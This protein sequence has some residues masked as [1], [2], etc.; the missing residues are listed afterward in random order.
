MVR[1]IL[2]ILFITC[3]IINIGILLLASKTDDD[4]PMNIIY[5]ALVKILCFVLSFILLFIGFPMISIPL[6]SSL[7]IYKLTKLVIAITKREYFL[8]NDILEI[9]IFIVILILLFW[10]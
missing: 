9:I 7:T 10:A 8:E 6:F 5:W 3:L 4:I 1:I 2:M